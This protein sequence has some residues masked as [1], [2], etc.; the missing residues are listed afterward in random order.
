MIQNNI[1]TSPVDFDEAIYNEER[2]CII[3]SC[4]GAALPILRVENIKGLYKVITDY[5]DGVKYIQDAIKERE[6]KTC[7]GEGVIYADGVPV[8]TVEFLEQ[9]KGV[10]LSFRI[11]LTDNQAEYYKTNG[12]L[13]TGLI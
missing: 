10:R 5:K 7:Y 4:S 6:L 9:L 1:Y 3:W 11:L 12:T 2:P 13:Y 8:P